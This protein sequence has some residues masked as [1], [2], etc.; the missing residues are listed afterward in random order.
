MCPI[1]C[2][3][4]P[5]CGALPLA[6]K[7]VRVCI[8]SRRPSIQTAHSAAARRERAS[9]PRPMADPIFATGHAWHYAAPANLG[10]VC[11]HPQCTPFGGILKKS[12]CW[13]R[14]LTLDP[15]AAA[16]RHGTR[17]SAARWRPA[18][19]HRGRDRRGSSSSLL[20]DPVAR[21]DLA[22]PLKPGCSKAV[23]SVRF[24]PSIWRK[25]R[26]SFGL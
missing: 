1:C 26:H 9:P 7:A 10:A 6:I 11:P 5:S 18:G 16:F 3:L 23:P 2:R 15:D 4:S 24:E 17:P 8:R 12:L 21:R 22:D 19:L 14:T 25:C 20:R 13:R